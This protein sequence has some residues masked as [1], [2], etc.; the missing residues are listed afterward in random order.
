MSIDPN[1][2]ED[3][4]DPEVMEELT[5]KFDELQI[6]KQTEHINDDP[7]RKWFMDFSIALGELGI[8]YS[9][10]YEGTI[11]TLQTSTGLMIKENS[12]MISIDDIEEY[13]YLEVPAEAVAAAI[14]AGLLS[15]AFR[16]WNRVG[17]EYEED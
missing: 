16:F 3:L 9:M 2:F 12:E 5:Q 4:F 8:R 11:L 15:P 1:D 13:R 7:K 10:N 17:E 14:K 6:K